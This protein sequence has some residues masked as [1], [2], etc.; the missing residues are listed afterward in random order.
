MTL[1]PTKE[2][3]KIEEEKSVAPS[4]APPT[5]NTGSKKPESVAPPVSEPPKPEEPVYKEPRT[6]SSGGIWLLAE[7]FPHAFNFLLLY[8]NPNKFKYS[9]IY[10]DLWENPLKPYLVDEKDTYIKISLKEEAPVDEKP[11][12]GK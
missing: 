12:A 10:K 8:H 1:S 11:A 7:D 9:Q 6:W 2:A 3:P 4:K 5:K